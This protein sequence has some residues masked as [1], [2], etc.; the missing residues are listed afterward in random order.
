MSEFRGIHDI[1]GLETE[2]FVAQEHDYEPWE[3]RVH[4]LRELLAT[5]GLLR[6]DELRRVVE[7]QGEDN[8]RRRSYYEQWIWAM[9]QVM[10]ERGIVSDAELGSC[11][12]ATR[13]RHPAPG[14]C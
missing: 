12:A 2:A 13:V 8:Y 1:G 14:S 11:I 9:A 3:K 5:K 10:L 7:S 4:A 6:V